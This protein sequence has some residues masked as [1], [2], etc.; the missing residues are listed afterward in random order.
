[1]PMPFS[2]LLIQTDTS[3]CIAPAKDHAGLNRHCYK[4]Q[5]TTKFKEQGILHRVLYCPLLKG[6]LHTALKTVLHALQDHDQ[7]CFGL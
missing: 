5:M 6:F 1:M 2:H 7:D 4:Q 3:V